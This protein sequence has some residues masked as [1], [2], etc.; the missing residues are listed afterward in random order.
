MPFKKDLSVIFFFLFL[1]F[2]NL[3]DA[4]FI[5]FSLD[6][7]TAGLQGAPYYSAFAFCAKNLYGYL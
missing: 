4:F 2:S 3:A 5:F 7:T 1:L 6:M